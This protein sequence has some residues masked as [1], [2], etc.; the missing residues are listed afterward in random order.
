M[1]IE[2]VELLQSLEGKKKTA[3]LSYPEILRKKEK[4]PLGLHFSP[5][6]HSNIQIIERRPVKIIFRPCHALFCK[7]TGRS[8]LTRQDLNNCLQNWG[9]RINRHCRRVSIKYKQRR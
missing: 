1:A 6:A 2:A 9:S 8:A 4:P 3:G 5:T 7:N